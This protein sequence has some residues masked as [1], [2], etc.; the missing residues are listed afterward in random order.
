MSLGLKPIFWASKVDVKSTPYQYKFDILKKVANG[1]IININTPVT[2]GIDA[3]GTTLIEKVINKQIS[4]KD[5]RGVYC[6][7]PC[8]VVGFGW[9]VYG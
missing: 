9:R 4:K 7:Q 1:D 2:S 8:C 6:L 3:Q 5:F